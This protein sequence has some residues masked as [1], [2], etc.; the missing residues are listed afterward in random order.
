MIGMCRGELFLLCGMIFNNIRLH[1][2]VGRAL[3]RELNLF[4]TL[5]A[6]HGLRIKTL[7]A[8]NFP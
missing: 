5:E 7:A 2:V 3:L 4:R 1:E 6:A 8:S